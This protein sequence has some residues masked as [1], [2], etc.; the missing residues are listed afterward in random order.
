MSST[1]PHAIRRLGRSTNARNMYHV[2][3]ASV[4][5]RKSPD[6]APC[7]GSTSAGS[8]TPSSATS[9]AAVS[10]SRCMLIRTT[11]GRSSGNA[12]FELDRSQRDVAVL[13]R[14]VGLPLVLQH[15]EA[16]DELRS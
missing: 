13:L 3:S 16:A 14:R 11:A 6:E 4:V 9:S 12:Y 15:L 1:E 7:P 10:P 5:T 8:P 2:C